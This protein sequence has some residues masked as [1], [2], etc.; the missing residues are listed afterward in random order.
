M[1]LCEDQKAVT[2]NRQ[3]RQTVVAMLTFK[4]LRHPAVT[5]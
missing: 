5:V 3:C 4:Y 1:R 2:L